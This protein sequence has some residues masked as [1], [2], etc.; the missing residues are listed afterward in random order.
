M[1]KIIP[2]LYQDKERGINFG[3]KGKR[4]LYVLLEL[5]KKI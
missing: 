4:V 3:I 1:S 2:K 5:L